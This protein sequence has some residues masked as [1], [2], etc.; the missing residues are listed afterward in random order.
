MQQIHDTGNV[1]PETEGITLTSTKLYDFCDPTERA[2]WLDILIALIEY[3]RSGESKVGFLNK[4]MDNNMLHKVQEELQEKEKAGDT[5]VGD[6]VE[7]TRREEVGTLRRSS[8]K[9]GLAFEEADNR[10]TKVRR[11][12]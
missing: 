4:S 7:A 10:D 1:A 6:V 11:Q 5:N 3:L 12:T 9:R 2:E 8:R